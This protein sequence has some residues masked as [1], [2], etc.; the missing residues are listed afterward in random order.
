MAELVS[1][2]V[3][4][5]RGT[6]FVADTLRSIQA[7][8]HRE[9]DVQISVDGNDA[10]SAEACR[11]FLADSRFSLAVQDR[12]LGWAGNISHLMANCRGDYWYYHQQDDLV[13][14]AYVER[15]LRHARQHKPA[16]T[17]SDMQIFGTMK[18]RIGQRAITG[19][20]ALRQVA[21]LMDHHS[22]VAF[23]GLVARDALQQAG[24][25][26]ENEVENFSADTT[27]MASAARAGELHRVPEVLY[28][29]RMHGANVHSKWRSWPLEKRKLAWQVHCRDMFLEAAACD[30]TPAE[31]AAIWSAAVGRLVSPRTAELY[32]PVAELGPE[33]LRSTLDGFLD[34]CAGH[35]DRIEAFLE[36][37]WPEISSAT[38]ELF[39]K[40]IAAANR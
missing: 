7:Q 36:N 2:G 24:G 32:L 28:Y 26:R 11:P 37:G 33:E 14:P 25:V 13:A 20:A 1:I 12:Q 39:G 18:G 31:R 3:P 4:V 40:A 16:I 17:Y 30:A 9:L 34:R 19:S 10:E 23:R 15:L 6:E 21:L 29:K 5:Y 27:F 35:T 38:R 8:T 22:A